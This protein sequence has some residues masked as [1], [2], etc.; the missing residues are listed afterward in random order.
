[1][2]FINPLKKKVD[3]GKQIQEQRQY[4]KG[5]VIT[6]NVTDQQIND[7]GVVDQQRNQYAELRRWQQDL[8]ASMRDIFEKLSG[9]RFGID[10]NPI[11]I[12]YVKP[13]MNINGAFQLVN[14]IEPLDKN[15]I[16]SNYSRDEIRTAMRWGIGYPLTQFIHDNCQDLGMQRNKGAMDFVIMLIMNTVEPTY[17]RAL[18]GGDRNVDSKIYKIN[19]IEDDRQEKEKKGLFK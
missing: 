18:N 3:E 11:P 16:N 19:R 14:F 13:L 12:G 10:G 1:M 15:L 4:E 8:S 2:E 7:E 6:H 9:M 5:Q 17:L